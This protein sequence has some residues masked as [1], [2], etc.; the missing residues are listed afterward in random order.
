MGLVSSNFTFPRARVLPNVVSRWGLC[1]F[2]QQCTFTSPL[3]SLPPPAFPHILSGLSFHFRVR[4]SPPGTSPKAA[5]LYPV[6]E[7]AP[8][9]KNGSEIHKT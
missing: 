8:F 2:R 1:V 3:D 4:Q 6:Q 5:S 9:L 7:I